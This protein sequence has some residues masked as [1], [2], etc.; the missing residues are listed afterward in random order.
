MAATLTLAPDEAL[1]ETAF[2]LD[3]R[4]DTITQPTQAMREA[5]RTARVG[6]DVFSEDPSINALEA[7]AAQIFG[8]EAAL[9]VTS[10][11]QG[12]LLALLS[13]THPGEEVIAEAG[14]HMANSEV[15]GAARLGGLT[16]RTVVGRAGKISP[17]QVA[18]TV[19]PENVHFARTTLLAV[20]NTH[21]NAGGTILRAEEMDRLAETARSCGL[22]IHVDGA[23][24]FNAAIGLGVEPL[25][26]ARHADTLTFCLSKGLSAPVGSVLVGSNAVI[27][28]ARRY[29]KMIGGGMRQAGVLAAAGL[30]ALDTGIGRLA[31]DHR[32][33]RR[34]AEGLARVPRVSIDLAS[35]QTNIVRFDIAGVGLSAAGLAEGFQQHGVRISG[36]PGTGVRMV[37]HRH[38]DDASVDLA[39]EAMV[40]IA[41]KSSNS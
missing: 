22:K 17:E 11:T 3:F 39:L 8:K 32:R 15:G 30:V 16:V 25:R 29:R 27:D 40:S 31:D 5:M 14:A 1:D 34:L 41:A 23:R 12:N 19:R 6:D 37:A 33:A 4:S 24:I 7:R 21:N 20:E 36:G 10:G 28:E 2:R 13:Q 26:L 9:F 38:I 35:V 18:S